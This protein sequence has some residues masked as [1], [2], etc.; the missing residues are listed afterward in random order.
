ML[1][2]RIMSSFIN[3]TK[4]NNNKKKVGCRRG[5]LSARFLTVGGV[6]NG[7][8]VWGGRGYVRLMKHE[9]RLYPA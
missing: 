3:K 5:E 7:Q 6:W 2:L 1:A 8:A 4:N 9:A